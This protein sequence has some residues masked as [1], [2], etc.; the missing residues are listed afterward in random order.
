MRGVILCSGFGERLGELTDK[1]PKPLIQ[2]NKKPVLRYVI[3]NLYQ[4]NITEI[5]INV[6]YLPLLVLKELN[7]TNIKFFGETKPLGTAGALLPM[8]QWL[9]D[10][11]ICHN[12][13][14]IIE[15][16]SIQ[17][18]LLQHKDAIATIFT[19]DTIFHNGGVFLFSKRIL[20]Y[21]PEMTSYS[22][23]ENLFHELLKRKEK[24]NI[25]DNKRAMYFD[26]GTPIG[27]QRVRKHFKHSRENHPNWKGGFPKCLDCGIV[28]SRNKDYCLE[29]AMKHYNTG[30][31]NHKWRGDNISYGSIHDW[32]QYHKGKPSRCLHSGYSDI[33]CSEKLEWA[34]KSH[35]AKR[36]LDDY[37][38]LCVRHHRLFD[39]NMPKNKYIR[40]QEAKKYYEQ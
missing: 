36:D 12:G 5:S 9:S 37:I 18:M 21:I 19:K 26:V 1:V 40:D 27:L 28:V 14:T 24:I 16:V 29:H 32:I 22:L 7:N 17:G 3:D 6:H 25:Y 34:S 23:H 15:N 33:P 31:K 39:G 30:E 38:P 35:K 4:Q 2:I 20:D 8:R 13:D 11:F 10:P